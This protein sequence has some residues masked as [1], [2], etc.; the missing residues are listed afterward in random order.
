MQ[1]FSDSVNFPRHIGIEL[2][3]ADKDRIEG[4]LPVTKD[5]TNH[6]PNVHG[7][8]IMSLANPMGAIGAH[9]NMPEGAAG[10]TTIESKTNF[11]KPAMLGDT[12]HAVATPL[13]VGRRLS[14]WQ[15]EITR[16]DCKRVAVVTQTQIYL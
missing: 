4:R 12:L 7:G 16:E 5:L 15:T 9:L 14:V 6:L 8:A 1:A 13:S 3:A 10:T 11:I 2:I